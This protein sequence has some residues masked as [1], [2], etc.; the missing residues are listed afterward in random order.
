MYDK[1][2]TFGS[3]LGEGDLNT[4][5][6]EYF[7]KDLRSRNGNQSFEGTENLV[8]RSVIGDLIT[9]NVGKVSYVEDRTNG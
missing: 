9:L 5:T 4:N 3:R 1:V 8:I 7:H 2:L 6:I